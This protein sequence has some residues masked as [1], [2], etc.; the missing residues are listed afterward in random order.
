MNLKRGE[1]SNA[2]MQTRKRS[3][4]FP[5][6]PDADRV[7]LSGEES[8]TTDGLPQCFSIGSPVSKLLPSQSQSRLLINILRKWMRLC[9][10]Q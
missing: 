6:P 2:L 7:E 4:A 10:L 5:H 8:V 9:L 1:R 3:K